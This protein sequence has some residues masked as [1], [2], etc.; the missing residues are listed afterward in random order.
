MSGAIDPELE[1][2]VAALPCWRGRIDIAP[3]AGGMT[4]RNLLVR[5][6][7]ARYVARLGEDIPVHGVLRFN[8]LAASRAAH[9]AGL[10]PEVVYA[11]PGVMILRHVEGRVLAPEDVRDPARL[12][13]LVRLV[14]RCHYDVPRFLRGPVLAFNAFH[15]MRNYGAAL[16]EGASPHARLV[17]DLLSRAAQLEA[18]AGAVDLVFGH[19]DLLAANI[20]DDGARLWLIDWDYAGF[21]SA[22]FDLGGLAS[23]N[24]FASEHERELLARYFGRAVDEDLWRR[25]GAMKCASLLRETMWSMVSELTSD[26]A[27]VDFA[28]YTREN[29]RR[30]EAAWSAMD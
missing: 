28:A 26:V 27:G 6:G 2:R 3:L 10:S 23:N 19:N 9:Q 11:E 14:R 1:A 4:N 5:D 29:L 21:G 8:E 24:G 12:D 17:D 7:S 25:Y 16:R 20:I 15:V 30:F 18:R 13:A 22:L